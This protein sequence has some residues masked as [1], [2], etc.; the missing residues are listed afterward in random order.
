MAWEE[1][2]PLTNTQNTGR[3]AR[4]SVRGTQRGEGS[5]CLKRL[6]FKR[7]QGRAVVLRVTR[8]QKQHASRPS[9]GGQVWLVVGNGRWRGAQDW[10]GCHGALR[11]SSEDWC[12][13]GGPVCSAKSVETAGQSTAEAQDLLSLGKGLVSSSWVCSA[14]SHEGVAAVW[15]LPACC[16]WWAPGL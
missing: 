6:E 14:P 1:A 10:K 11:D 15:L 3:Q 13:F 8:E 7:G 5:N 12:A 4:C 16:E 2:D 9:G